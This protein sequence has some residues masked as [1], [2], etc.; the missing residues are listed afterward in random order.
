MAEQ[1]IEVARK[2]R[3]TVITLNRPEV[4][5]AVHP[6]A[7]WELHEAFDAFESDP[8]QWVAIVTGAGERAFC[9]GNDLK[10]HAR[11]AAGRFPPTGFGGL[12]SRFSMT[13]PLIAAVNGVA[14]GGGFEMALACDIILASPNAQFA[15]PEP[16]VGLAAL[17]G[18]LLR[19]PRQIGLPRAMSMILTARRVSA[20]EGKALGF[21]MEIAPQDG[22]LAAAQELAEQICRLSPLAIRASKQVALEGLNVADL[23]AATARQAELPAVRALVT[24]QDFLEGPRAFAEKRAPVWRG[25]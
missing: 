14:M 9:A 15:L 17:G 16:A 3:V 19:L 7:S 5:N 23:A 11:G 1:F 25:A 20:D 13:K 8:D 18:G 2:G 22:L 4:M 6:P 12:T 10:H 21:V 24:S